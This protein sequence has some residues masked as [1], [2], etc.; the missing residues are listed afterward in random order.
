[1]KTYKIKIQEYSP[2]WYHKLFKKQQPV[3]GLLCTDFMNSSGK[4]IA[5]IDLGKGNYHLII[6]DNLTNTK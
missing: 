4:I 6:E 5:S 1:M 3:L 2:K